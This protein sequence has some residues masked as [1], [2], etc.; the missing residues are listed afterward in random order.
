[1]RHK[2][3]YW[4]FL[5]RKIPADKSKSS[6]LKPPTQPWEGSR[7]AKQEFT[8]GPTAWPAPGGG[9]KPIWFPHVGVGWATGEKRLP[10]ARCTPQVVPSPGR[11]PLQA[12]HPTTARPA[13]GPPSPQS[14]VLW[15]IL[16]HWLCQLS[17]QE[18][19]LLQG[20]SRAQA[21]L[22]PL[23]AAGL[24][25]RQQRGEEAGAAALTL[26]RS[27]PGTGGSSVDSVPLP[28]VA[29]PGRRE[30]RGNPAC[31]VP[32]ENRRGTPGAHR[33]HGARD[34]SGLDPRLP[35]GAA[36]RVSSKRSPIL[37]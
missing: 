18:I 11:T 15:L 25:P 9:L 8:Q 21:P 1:M 22:S 37:R 30:S 20:Q 6:F 34:M 10:P 27:R 35:S 24:A 19:L 29:A 3:I 28:P 13:G 26:G 23:T 16:S 4:I 12:G 33:S 32:A 31:R 5:N 2:D 7:G 14:C 17:V 36:G